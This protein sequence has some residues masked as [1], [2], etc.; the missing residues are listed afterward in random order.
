MTIRTLGIFER[1]LF[2]SD[3]HGPFNVVSVL[4][5]ENPPAPNIVR[6]ALNILQKR[7]PLLQACIQ[8]GKFARLSN[9]SFSFQ[10]MERHPDFNWLDIVEQE[11]NTRLNPENGLFRGVCSYGSQYADLILTFHH[12]IMD[13]ASGMNLLD[14]LLRVCAA[15]QANEEPYLPT[16]KIVPPVEEQFPASFRGW[17]GAA[18]IMKYS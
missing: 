4:R 16:L 17:R 1:A 6:Q 11:M 9:L 10:V 14:E 12:A 13:A 15:L 7:H 3:Q 8:N 2:L 18:K 5:L